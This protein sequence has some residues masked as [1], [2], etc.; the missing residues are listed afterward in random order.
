MEPYRRDPKTQKA[1]KEQDQE[2]ENQAGLS[3]L[4]P[5]YVKPETRIKIDAHIYLL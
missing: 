3:C 4:V 2:V 5:R 1:E